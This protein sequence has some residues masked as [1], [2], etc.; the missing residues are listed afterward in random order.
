VQGMMGVG[1]MGQQQHQAQGM[2]DVGGV[3]HQQPVRGKLGMVEVLGD[4]LE[5][6][7]VKAETTPGW[8]SAQPDLQVGGVSLTWLD[9][10]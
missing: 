1:G 7:A 3:G 5:E 4:L 8:P 10:V 2:V 6:A 9:L